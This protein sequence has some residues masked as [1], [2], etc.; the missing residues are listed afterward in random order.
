MRETKEFD[1]F[2]VKYRTREFSA[3]Y[4]FRHM[5]A[6]LELHPIELLSATEV[7]L[8]DGAWA[9]L[10][11]PRAIDTHVRDVLGF[12]AAHIVF[13]AVMAQVRDTTW[14]FL[15]DWKLVKIPRRFQSTATSVDRENVNPFMSRI[16]AENRASKRELEE[17]YSLR[18]AFD[19]Y[20][21]ICLHSLNS[22]IQQ[23]AAQKE[24]ERKAG[25]R[26]RGG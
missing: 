24:A 23:E 6:R 18:D 15:T 19:M 2:G 7:Q 4:G 22:L 11:T 14:G 1:A 20:D 25:G 16:V 12:M 13:E 17:Y 5:A 26:G 10:D 3:A 21:E 9:R 8:S